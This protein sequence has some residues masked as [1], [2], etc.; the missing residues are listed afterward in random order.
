MNLT[1]FSLFFPEKRDFFIENSGLFSFGDSLERASAPEG[2]RDLSLFH[3]RQIGLEREQPV[4]ILAGA[5]LSGTVAKFQLGVLN[6]Q[7]E[8]SN[9]G[10]AEN[11]SVVRVRRNLR[12]KADLGLM[13]VN[14]EAT[15][16]PP[17]KRFNRS[18]G[19]DAHMRPMRNLTVNCYLAATTESEPRPATT[20]GPVYSSDGATRSGTSR[21]RQADGAGIQPRCRV[22]PAPRH[23]GHVRDRRSASTRARPVASRR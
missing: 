21:L 15:A 8:K 18:Y 2:V 20:P 10:P 23:A 13:F 9:L 5:R 22:R 1:R 12:G 17:D 4:P 16:T 3:S 19:V 6:M 11:F 14:R 7:T